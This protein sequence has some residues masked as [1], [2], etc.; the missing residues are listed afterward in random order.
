MPIIVVVLFCHF[1]TAFTALG[2]PLFLPRMLTSLGVDASGSLVGVLF[3]LP[4]ICTALT[5]PFWGRFAD[6]FGKKKSLLRAQLGLI[7]GFL[8]SGFA[9]SLW[10]FALGLIVQ[11]VSG[12]TLAASNA[13]LS[14]L[15]QGKALA[16]S[17]NLTQSSARLALVS[18]PIILGIFTHVSQPLMIYRTLALLP[19]AAFIIC[20]F[21]PSDRAEKMLENQA[22]PQVANANNRIGNSTNN[23]S[24]SSLKSVTQ[25]NSSP[26]LSL[27]PVF[28]L[29]FLFNFSMVVTFPYF[30][31]YSESLGVASD[32]LTGFY[33]SLPHLVYLLFAFQC[34]KLTIT[35]KQQALLGLTLLGVASLGQFLITSSSALILLRVIFGFGIVLGYSGLHLLMSQNLNQAQAGL[36]FGRFDAWGKWAGVLA[37]LSASLISQALSLAWPFLLAA[38]SCGLGLMLLAVFFKKNNQRL[39]DDVCEVRN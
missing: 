5:A 17:L 27:Y 10:L 23:R 32:P 34:K 26:V 3:I 31:P 37:G 2:M 30:L 21:L 25:L 20:C 11:G 8:L 12:G 29:Q 13:Y 35:A 24:K 16:N 33:Y 18:A 9:D 15:Y 39:N 19:L 1:L 6:R 4:T 22:S 36:S 28:G 14:R 7:C 38:I